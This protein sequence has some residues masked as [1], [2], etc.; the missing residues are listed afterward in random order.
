MSQLFVLRVFKSGE[1]VEVKQ[2]DTEQIV[3]GRSGDAQLTI[4]DS[5]IS[6]LHCVIENR[7]GKYFVSDLGSE[8]GTYINNEKVLEVE[9]Q[10]GQELQLGNFVIQFNVGVP[11]PMSQTVVNVPV[12]AQE[13]EK[14]AVKPKVESKPQPEVETKPVEVVPPV[15][16]VV[17]PAQ[18]F[19]EAQKPV[20]N[21][22][23]THPPKNKQTFAPTGAFKDIKQFIKPEKGTVIEVLVAWGDRIIATHHF[24]KAGNVNIG[25]DPSCE[26]T[27]PLMGTPL[28][29]H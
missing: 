11:K 7:E 27:L 8:T 19:V 14:K 17:Q 20:E 10:S 23:S 5:S 25:T 2:F 24:S 18:Q 3:I 15:E 13:P 16:K 4:D 26:I 1:L 6:P 29:K 28:R 22:K 12:M 9:L 21:I